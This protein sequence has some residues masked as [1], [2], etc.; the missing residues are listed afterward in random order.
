MNKLVLMIIVL[1]T[2]LALS[3]CGSAN[4]KEEPPAET[5]PVG[6]NDKTPYPY[7]IYKGVLIED[8]DFDVVKVKLTE[9]ELDSE[10]HADV[11]DVISFEYYDRIDDPV[12]KVSK[13]LIDE[14]LVKDTEVEISF[15][16]GDAEY[17]KDDDGNLFIKH[18]KRESGWQILTDGMNNEIPKQYLDK[19]G[20]QIYLTKKEFKNVKKE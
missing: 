16:V 18:I 13:Y 12:R 19:N 15:T 4:A 10:H 11:G 3:S 14:V 5:E 8:A 6:I 20:E 1:S 2:C 17:T 7:N 9:I